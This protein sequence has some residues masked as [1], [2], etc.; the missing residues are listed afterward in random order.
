MGFTRRQTL[1]GIAAGAMAAACPGSPP[2]RAQPR[3]GSEP[4]PTRPIRIVVPYGAGSTTDMTMRMIAP[5]MSQRLGQPL[6]IDN[7]SGATG[8]IG[9][10]AVAKSPPDGYTLVMGTVASHGTLVPLMP[11]L[12][13]DVLRDFTPIGLATTPPGLVVIHP[14]VPARTLA[15]F[16]AYSKTQ[17]DGV[18]YA[19]SGVGGSGHLATELLRLKTGAKIVHVPYRDVGRGISDL[20]AGRVK[21][22]IY[23]A[24]VLPHIRSGALRGLA[25]LS[26]RRV[27]FAPDLPTAIEQGVPGLVASGWQG[28]FGPAGLPDTI[29]D[30]IYTAMKDTL[31]DP[32][33]QPLLADQ[34]QEIA[35]MPGPE[36]QRFVKAE[37]DKWAEVVKVAD[38]RLD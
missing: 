7:K 6:V 9:S 19:S 17:P 28:L 36:F 25:V 14:S 16:V 8:A 21:M 30:Q 10:D 26:E 29:R 12:P 31:L 15:E 13:Y 27:A 35:L 22:M 38:I 33:I 11:T 4:F 1:I 32:G 34:G 5:R 24:P 3:A 23:Y 18:D 2:P 37:I 20:L